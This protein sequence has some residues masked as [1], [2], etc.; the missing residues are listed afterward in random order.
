MTSPSSDGHL[1]ACLELAKRF[2]DVTGGHAKA[3]LEVLPEGGV[4]LKYLQGCPHS[5]N[6]N[7]Q[8]VYEDRLSL[9]RAM[10]SLTTHVARA[11]RA[12]AEGLELA[13]LSFTPTSDTEGVVLVYFY[14]PAW[15]EPEA[16]P[17]V[18]R[19]AGVQGGRNVSLEL[20]GPA[21][22]NLEQSRG[23]DQMYDAG[24]VGELTNVLPLV[25][26]AVG[27]FFM[28]SDSLP[29]EART[30]L[31]PGAHRTYTEFPKGDGFVLS[32]FG[33]GAGYWNVYPQGNILF[34]DTPEGR[35]E[36]PLPTVRALK[37]ALASWQAI[38]EAIAQNARA[39][40][41]VAS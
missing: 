6:P 40:E 11:L 8:V 33:T 41:E 1:T 16:L 21:Q 14:C 25:N 7:F 15:H 2:A 23:W 38:G 26:Q 5:S 27:Q 31:L 20:I 12:N 35:R 22:L 13:K 34:V 18:Y 28:L 32:D 39:E 3:D 29:L 19:V 10:D 17:C 4:N 37:S 30:V 36:L 24:L 9:L